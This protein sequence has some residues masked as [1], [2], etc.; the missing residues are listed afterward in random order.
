M[1]TTYKYIRSFTIKINRDQDRPK[2]QFKTESNKHHISFVT[3]ETEVQ[4][5]LE[6]NSDITSKSKDVTQQNEQ[7]YILGDAQDIN[8]EPGM[9]FLG[10]GVVLKINSSNK[11]IEI[12]SSITGFPAIFLYQNSNS[13]IVTSEIQNFTKIAGLNL[14]FD[15]KG[16]T[17]FATIGHPINHRT[18]FKDI[19]VIPAGNQFKLVN[20]NKLEVIGKWSPS[21]E[22]I[23]NSWPD[24]IEAQIE[25][26][27]SATQRIDLS[28][29]FLSLTAGLDTRAIFALLVQEKIQIPAYTMSGKQTS[30]DALRARQLCDAYNL[31]HNTIS[32]DSGFSELLPE[33]A[34]EASRLSGGLGS[35]SQA[36][37]VY[38]YKSLPNDLTSRLSGNLGNQ[39]GRSGTEGTGMRNASLNFLAADLKAELSTKSGTHWFNDIFP[40]QQLMHP[41]FL[42]Q[43]ESLYASLGNIC[44]G[45]HFTIQH[46]PY[47]D[48]TVISQKLRQ[49]PIPNLHQKQESIWQ[50][51]IRDLQHRLFGQPLMYSFQ[52]RVVKDTGGFVA[53]CPINWGWRARGGVSLGGL[54][55]GILSMADAVLSSKLSNHPL[56]SKILTSVGIHGLSGFQVVDMLQQSRVKQFVADTLLSSN[57][58]EAGIFDT[59]EIKQLVNLGL[60]DP[61]YRTNLE[62]A[63]DVALAQ[64]NFLN[65]SQ[66]EVIL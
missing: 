66:N 24:Y 49:P 57:S 34:I 33:Y 64:N 62:F 51:K 27:R 36:F 10:N 20:G 46:S 12:F 56:L 5:L 1:I 54:A 16:I 30:L 38:F 53:N 44:I 48:R 25:A 23:F 50:I 19:S 7:F 13:T 3:N 18:L 35:I 42:I 47:A 29:A 60:S 21:D 59:N 6:L 15:P 58:L 2:S 43:N 61:R 9:P 55:Y 22:P 39:I 63:L 40:D 28:H 37:E 14:Q 65:T 41:L 11:D 8:G 31:P 45:S 17:E 52:R 32:I 26:M 4:I